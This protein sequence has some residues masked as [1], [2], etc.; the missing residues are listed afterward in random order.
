MCKIHYTAHSIH[1]KYSIIC[2][3]Y[4]LGNTL[5]TINNEAFTMHNILCT[6]LYSIYIIQ[7]SLCITK[8]RIYTV[9]WAPKQC[10]MHYVIYMRYELYTIHTLLSIPYYIIC[11]MSYSLY[12]V[13]F[14]MEHK[15]WHIHDSA[16][17]IHEYYEL[18]TISNTRCTM[19][20]TLYN[21]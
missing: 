10:S 13:Q 15:L 6:V 2:I 7:Y 4:T 16:I 17:T 19:H 11:N 1:N 5:C 3:K 14:T 8:Y 20:Y 21:T 12:N 9:Y 18:S